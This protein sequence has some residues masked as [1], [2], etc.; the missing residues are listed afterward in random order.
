MNKTVGMPRTLFYYKAPKL[1]EVFFEKL[2]IKLVLSD[3]TNKKI[4]ND[5]LKLSDNESCLSIKLLAGHIVDL[6]DK[7]D[8]IFIPKYGSE[9]KNYFSCPKFLLLPHLGELFTKYNKKIIT[10]EFNLSKYSTKISLYKLGSKL[11]HNPWKIYFATKQAISAIKKKKNNRQID[12]Q[13]KIIQNRTKI[14]I[15]S[16]PYIIHDNFM[17]VDLFKKLEKMDVTAISIEEVPSPL[18]ETYIKWDFANKFL[19]SLDY[20]LDNKIKIDG[21]IQISNF[22]CGCDSVIVDLIKEKIKKS[23]LHYLNLIIDEH[24]GE[25]GIITRLE[26]FIDSIRNI[27]YV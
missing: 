5:S 1:W 7:C 23:G 21:L 11:S 18:K 10:E 14:L 15:I 20:L 9:K 12:F 4:L 3:L 2:G 17:N 16:H 6:K 8:I 24:T 27:N 22:N 19:N 25:A 13:K 26:A